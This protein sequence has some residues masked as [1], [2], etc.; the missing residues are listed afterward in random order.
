MK[1]I[2]LS[3]LALTFGLFSVAQSNLSFENWT[4]GT[5]DNWDY[6]GTGQHMNSFSLIGDVEDGSGNPVV[7]STEQTTGA[8]AGNSY[9]RMTS[10]EFVNSSQPG[11]VPDGP[12]G[13]INYQTWATADRYEDLTFDVKY[14]V[15]GS[16][17]AVFVVQGLD[18][19]GD[20]V[21]Q[22]VADFTGTQAAFAQETVTI[23]YVSSD[24][25]QDWE[26]I[27]SSSVGEV[28]TNWNGNPAPTPVPTSELDV[29]NIVFGAVITQ[30]P[31]V[32]NVVASDISDNGDGTD[33]EVTFDVAADETDV[34]N[35]YAVTFESGEEYLIGALQDPLAF[36]QGNGIQVT[37][38]GS[39]QT[40]VFTAADEA[41][42]LN[43]AG[44]ALES[45]P[46]TEN[47]AY[48]VVI[49]VEGANGAVDVWEESNE[50]TL[51]S[52]GTGSIADQWKNNF[53][54]YP[55]PTTNN[56]TFDFAGTNEVEAVTIMNVN[57]AVVKNIAVNGQSQVNANISELAS[58]VYI[59]QVISNEG[60]AVITNK[61]MKK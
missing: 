18:A 8:T 13:S 47:Q 54:V 12:Y 40:V 28:F 24:P 4:S 45:D 51:T 44:T 5:P 32:S 33:L 41:Y 3:A 6:Y 11:Q 60:K 27:M 9:I 36:V 7:P 15:Q 21:A 59:Y 53:N 16:D 50:V 56:V 55:N 52:A 30:A 48:V 25:I 17:V 38:N 10:F 23:Q 58:G 26:I 42:R 43:G 1:K 57:G 37:P 34:A 61:I 29:D 49:Y 20:L 2:Y 46:I 39:S 19:N 22:G 31:N 35:Y 14:D